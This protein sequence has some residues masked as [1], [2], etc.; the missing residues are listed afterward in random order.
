M[1][2][3]GIVEQPCEPNVYTLNATMSGTS[4]SNW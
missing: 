2:M 3:R 1:G 4:E